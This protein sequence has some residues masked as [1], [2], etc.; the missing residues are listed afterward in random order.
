M[1]ASCIFVLFCQASW[2]S[3]YCIFYTAANTVY[4]RQDYA[5]TNWHKLFCWRFFLE[6][7]AFIHFFLFYNG[8]IL[9][10]MHITNW[11][12]LHK[13]AVTALGTKLKISV[14]CFSYAEYV[15]RW[16]QSS[17]K[18]RGLHI[19]S[20]KNQWFVTLV[21]LC[22]QLLVLGALD[23]KFVCSLLIGA[24]QVVANKAQINFLR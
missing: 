11:I 20:N 13:M 3:R 15:T 9:V 22:S 7:I 21:C 24:T 10:Y 6:F 4:L 23:T 14:V 18:S 2:Q 12:N 17:Y 16:I 8:F 5:K 1:V 19:S